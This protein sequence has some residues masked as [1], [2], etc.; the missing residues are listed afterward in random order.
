MDRQ[1]F[2]E[3]YHMSLLIAIASSVAVLGEV[4]LC[5]F[6]YINGVFSIWNIAPLAMIGFI[7]F[8]NIS[9][10]K[11]KSATSRE[12]IAVVDKKSQEMDSN[13]IVNVHAPIG[14]GQ[15]MVRLGLMTVMIAVAVGLYFTWQKRIEKYDNVVTAT[16]I[17]QEN[18]TNYRV[19]Y[20]EYLIDNEME[21][22][23][24]RYGTLLL[25]YNINGETVYATMN[26]NMGEVYPDTIEICVN[27]EGKFL[28]PYDAAVNVYYFEM[29]VFAVAGV[30]MMLSLLFVLP[31]EFV[32]FD[33]MSLIGATLMFLLNSQFLANM[34]YVD[35]TAFLG[36][37]FFLGLFGMI[38]TLFTKIFDK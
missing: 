16:V 6:Q 36:L 34:L 15:I 31:V 27:D 26:Q 22:T 2:K 11:G 14:F 1:T 3:K 17:G 9:I 33:V 18:Y 8:F 30:L 21:V 10:N 12:E 38:G 7:L 19:D 37:F 32:I 23:E 5:I 28:K 29:I 20:E 24:I 13:T 4:V 25:A 35:M